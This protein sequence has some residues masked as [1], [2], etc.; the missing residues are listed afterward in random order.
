MENHIKVS[1]VIPAY[2]VEKYIERCIKSA[3]SQTL[4]K[5]EI[6]V[7]NDG[8]TDK[9]QEIIERLS[10]KDT[11]IIV[12]NKKNGG[13]LNA[14]KSGLSIAK[15][16]YIQALDGDDWIEPTA[17]EKMYNFA[18]KENLDIVISDFYRDDDHGNIEIWKDL[19]ESKTF[20]TSEE[21]LSAL[22]QIKGKSYKSVW[23]KLFSRKLYKDIIFPEDISLGE[24][25]FQTAVLASKAT[26]IGKYN[27]AFVHYIV[28]PTS[29]TQYQ[30]SKKMYHIFK[31]F[32]YIEKNFKRDGFYKTYKKML[33][34]S[35]LKLVYTF[36][37]QKPY[38][39]DENYERGIEKTLEYFKCRPKIYKNL[40][41][42]RRL[43]MAF[44]RQFPSREN[45][46]RMIKLHNKQYF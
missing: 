13:L 27:E 18:K 1:I 7:V 11:R 33:E 21:Y 14:R 40:N 23:N 44:L 15:G 38:F 30:A 37:K 39:G 16:E 42:T 32:E 25:F 29:L 20:Y 17:C 36:L 31:V 5:I 10:L 35:K 26:K 43:K 4:K 6:I 3:I 34:Q 9:T 22:F 41:F 45:I 2:N 12:I 8:S 24:D 46:V 28:N 19:N